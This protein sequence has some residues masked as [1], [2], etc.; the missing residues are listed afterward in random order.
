MNSQ[1][2][3]FFKT[4]GGVCQGCLLS[5]ILFNMFSEIRQ[6]TF[7]D[8][9]TSIYTGERPICNLRFAD[10]VNLMGGS[11]GELKD[12]INRLVDRAMAYG[13]KS[14]RKRAKS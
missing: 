13:R 2:W 4:K 14:A 12:L 10:D 9:Q 8:H 6:E 5:P 7:H 1:L 3:E 11:N